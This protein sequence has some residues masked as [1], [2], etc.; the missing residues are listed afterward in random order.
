MKV[1]VL[2]ESKKRKEKIADML[3][4]K[5]YDVMACSATGEFME[6]IET[7]TPDRILLDVDSWKHGKVIFNY[8]KFSKKLTDVPIFFYNAPENFTSI[9]DRSQHQ[10]DRVFNRQVDIDELVSSV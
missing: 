10:S 2:D 9:V 3:E 5:G 4:E 7:L 1:I 6:T 8:F